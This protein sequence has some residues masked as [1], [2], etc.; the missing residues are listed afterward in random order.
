V[1]DVTGPHETFAL[2]NQLGDAASPRYALSVVAPARGPLVA[3]SGLSLGPQAPV[4][5]ESNWVKTI[6]GR[7]WWAWFRVYGPTEPYYDKSWKLPDFEKV[8][9]SSK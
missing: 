6:P 9:S 2:A 3:S 4:G 5:K 8:G 1:L 7:G